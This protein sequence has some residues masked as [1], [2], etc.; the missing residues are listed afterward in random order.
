MTLTHGIYLVGI[1]V[2]GLIN[3][4]PVL[5]VLSGQ[6]IGDAYAISVSSVEL[7][8]LLRHRALL[9]GVVGGFVLTS[10]WLPQ[11]RAPAL[12]IAG[13]SMAGFLLLAA[14]VGDFGPALARIVVADVVGMLALGTALMLHVLH[15]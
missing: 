12:A 13:I 9:F 15:R 2:V 11:Y 4:L 5:G 1:V 14:I 3:T 7:E 6:R 10:L 8:I